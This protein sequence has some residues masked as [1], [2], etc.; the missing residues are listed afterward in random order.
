MANL[1][2]RIA[3][4]IE[5]RRVDAEIEVRLANNELLGHLLIS[6]GSLDWRPANARSPHSVR[7][8]AFAKWMEEYH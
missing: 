4:P 5:V 3:Q 7:W 6:K 8:R 2:L 1:K